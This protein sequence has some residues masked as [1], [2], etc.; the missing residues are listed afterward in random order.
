MFTILDFI[1]G[2]LTPH[3]KLEVIK[4]LYA[5]DKNA[6]TSN[7]KNNLLLTAAKHGCAN[8]VEYLIT[9][10]GCDANTVENN[11][12]KKSPALSA[13]SL[14]ITNYKHRQN[15]RYVET[16][17]ILLNH[18]ATFD[19]DDVYT[20]VK[21]P[22]ILIQLTTHLQNGQKILPKAA[23]ILEDAQIQ[24]ALAEQSSKTFKM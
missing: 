17:K 14:T 8:I 1:T 16:V 24:I 11:F 13:L 10:H 6:I 12:L 9:E 15:D 23:S 19:T 2:P 3:K 21:T 4:A 18:G 5:Y 7:N 22:D 20:A